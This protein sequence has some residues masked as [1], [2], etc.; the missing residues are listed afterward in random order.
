VKISEIS[1]RRPVFAMV[2]SLLLIILGLV[3]LERLTVR[4]YPDVD[5]PVVSV[6]T[7]YRGASAQVVENKI[8]QPLEDVLAGIEGVEKL[9]SSSRDERSVIIIEFTVE[10]NVDAAANDVRDRVARVVAALPEEAEPPQ[11]AKADS[12]ADPIVWVNFASDRMSSL[13]LTDYGERYIVDRLSV[14]PG[15]ANIQMSGN[16]RYAMRI[17]L[18][19]HA[20]AARGLTVIDVE[21]ALRRENVMLPAG[22]IESREREFT[23]RTETGLDTPE[24]FRQLVVGRGPEG[25]MVR[26]GEV[27]RVELAAENERTIARTAGVAGTAFGALQQSKANTLQVSR[28]LREQV[29]ALQSELPKGAQLAINIDRALFIEASLREVVYAIV[30]SLIAVLVVIYLFLGNLRATLIPAVTI[31]V[32]IVATF[33]VMDALGYTINVLTL[34]GIVLAIGLVVD[35]AIVVLENIF[36]K[37]ESGQPPL[38]AAIDGSREIGFAVVATTLTLVAVF[39]PLSFLPGNVGRLFREFGFTIAA[40]IGFSSLVALTLTPMMASKLIKG[41]KHDGRVAVAVD[42]VF[43][44]LSA[45]YSRVVNAAIGAPWRFV[46]LAGALFAVSVVLLVGVPGIVAPLPSAFSPSDDRGMLNVS[47]TGPEGM[48]LEAAARYADELEKIMFREQQ[49]FGDILRFNIRVPGGMG[50][51]GELNSVRSFAVLKDWSE[52]R[53]SA[54]DIAASLQK[55]VA[56]LPGMRAFVSSQ[57]GGIGGRSWGQSPVQA[58]IGGPDYDALSQWSAKLVKLA[59]QNPGL[60]NVDTNYKERKPQMRVAVDRNRAGDLGVSL[61]AVGRTLETVLGSRIVTT[62]VDRGREYNVILQGPADE[63]AQPSDLTNLYVRSDRNGALVPLSN[64]VTLVE[65]AGAVEL[66]RFDRLRS[67]TISAN[68]A[69]GYSMGD[70]VKWF[71]DTVAKELPPTARLSWDGES[72]DFVKSSGQMYTTFAFA[73]AVVFLVLAAQFES[74][75]HPIVILTTV[76]LAV[77]GSVLGLKIYQL[78]GS[79]AASV[80]IFS[81]IALIMLIGIAAKNGVLIVEFA[82]QLRDRGVEFRDAIHDAAVARLRPV[83]MTSLCTAFGAL[84]FL[85]AHGAG[86]EQREPIGIVVFFGTMVSV[87]LT[88]FVV[89][90]AYVLIAKNTKSPEYVAQLIERLRG[91]AAAGAPAG[92]H[93]AT[94]S[95]GTGAGAAG[96]PTDAVAKRDDGP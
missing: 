21:N 22:R 88:L 23:L 26:L 28:G 1:I 86:A 5:R 91:R 44:G 56:G 19:R 18:D 67:V 84:P 20:L 36:K 92:D 6:S 14:V 27:A 15:V 62:Y 61:Q 82:N 48:S 11:I 24:D 59:E 76:P 81:Q 66:P 46:A 37:A 4:E 75:R 64:L 8:T 54:K 38:L 39:V 16:R 25:Y 40:A 65:T 63:R 30:F 55:K 34:L 43:A 57:M 41:G 89:P 58:V 87:L 12:N 45:Y 53:R 96:G 95:A 50:G 78:A 31:P 73:L 71:Q 68:L 42:R 90:A 93:G 69:P 83:L 80:N 85:F 32:S 74:F 47:L 35:D 3:A 9:E 77:V 72:R 52:R 49:E 70:A 10:R 17:W 94:P 2:I 51:T 13:E 7:T 79:D 33:M 29:A 60:V